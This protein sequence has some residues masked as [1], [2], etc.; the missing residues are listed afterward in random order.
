[1][2]IIGINSGTSLDGVDIVLVEYNFN[3]GKIE[4]KLLFYEEYNYNLEFK[5]KLK[6]LL[7]FENDLEFICSMNF[8]IA[9]QFSYYINEFIK[10]YSINKNEVSCIASHGQTVWHNPN[11][12]K[13]FYKSTLQ[14]GDISALSYLTNIDVVGNFRT[15]DVASNG[16]GAPLMPVYDYFIHQ[17]ID[18]DRAYI[19]LGGI[20]NVTYIRCNSTKEDVIAFDM[21]PANLLIDKACKRFLN[22]E[23]DKNGD[24]AKKG[25]I[26][27]P[28][29]D[30]LDRKSVV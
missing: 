3:N 11:P 13:G 17:N 29:F 16:E 15:K 14:L 8:E 10:K 24:E 23:Y 9:F 2:K 25:E 7:I 6:K 20:S 21:G 28:L 26:I 27:L 30:F 4:E 5:E 1:M 12:K 18:K 22:I 19:N